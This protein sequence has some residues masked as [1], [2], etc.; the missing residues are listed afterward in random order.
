LIPSVRTI[1]VLCALLGTA[2]LIA[3]VVDLILPVEI[4]HLPRWPQSIVWKWII[5]FV[6]SAVFACVGWTGLALHWGRRERL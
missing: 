6:V 2:L 5:H 1:L 4:V 3:G